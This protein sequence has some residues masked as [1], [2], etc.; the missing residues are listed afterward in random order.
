[1]MN[2]LYGG[3]GWAAGLWVLSQSVLAQTPAPDAAT[4]TTRSESVVSSTDVLNLLVNEGVISKE[5]ALKMLNALRIRAERAK[6]SDANAS[7]EA[8]QSIVVPYI[9]PGVE[10][11]IVDKIQKDL[12]AKTIEEAKK[13]AVGMPDWV[14]QLQVTGDV[15]L[16]YNAEYYPGDNPGDAAFN[17]NEINSE[18]DTASAGRDA[19]V[20]ITENRHRLQGRARL[21]FVASAA[22]NVKMGMRLTSG[23][24][25]NPVSA[26][27]TLGRYGAKWESNFDLAYIDYRNDYL[28]LK[29][30]RFEKPW[31]TTDLVWDRD[32]TFEGVFAQT[33]P[34]GNTL[35]KS[36]WLTYLNIGALPIQEIHKYKFPDE[37]A[38]APDDKWLY[39]AGLGGQLEWTDTHRLEAAVTYYQYK[40]VIGVRNP[41]GQDSQNPSAP[42]IFQ[43]GNVVQNIAVSLPGEDQKERYALA[44]EFELVDFTLQYQYTGLSRHALT[45]TG[46]YVKNKAWDALMTSR[47]ISAEG[48]LPD[49]DTGLQ[50]EVGFGTKT[51]VDWGDWGASITYRRLEGDAVIDAF[52]DSD[53]L[54]GGTNAQGFIIKAQQFLTHNVWLELTATSADEVDYPIR[55]EDGQV[56]G[57]LRKR[58]VMLDINARF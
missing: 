49:R 7:S 50:L 40:N 9:S 6:Q 38:Y 29:G 22:K 55:Q 36:N 54:I 19:W 52:A 25:G 20:N 5:V 4:A 2:K 56:L 12:T 45:V 8:D 58:S 44:S 41:A 33:T 32:M 24:N 14:K 3:V 11:R 18:G 31:L 10:A 42:R 23:E 48:V 30:G 17:F 1:M 16:R 37:A 27:Q 26:N 53:F 34:F 51:R 13:E 47:V 43:F 28:N 46:D 39:T 57:D 15:R 21:G 35:A